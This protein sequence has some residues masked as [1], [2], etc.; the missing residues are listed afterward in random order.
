MTE[1]VYTMPG[2]CGDAIHQWPVVYHWAKQTG[3]KAVIWL[4]ENTCKMLKPLM[5]AQSY[6]ER[7]EF[8]EG[9]RSYQCGGQPWHFDLESKDFQDKRIFHLGLRGFPQRQLTLECI[10]HCKVQL[11][12]TREEIAS[13]PCFEVL[14]QESKNRLVLHGMP[15][16]PHTKTTPQFWKF[17]AGVRSELESEFDEIVF[18]GSD[19]DREVGQRIYPEWLT[20]DDKGDFN[21]LANYLAA[22]RAMIGCGS[23]PVALAGALK[24]PAIR[25]HDPI[26]EH[27][28]VIWS[29]LGDNQVNATEM[30][31]RTLWPEWRDKWL[32]VA[33]V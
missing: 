21:Q 8:R 26:G 9:I 3:K 6:V 27:P 29:N 25:V 11:G 5:E 18:V 32:G 23:A 10:E 4:D 16:C 15:V 31:L 22:S 7:V 24:I 33:V 20:F 2:K 19:R 17:L 1:T 12:A 30:D 14:P 28:K 13:T